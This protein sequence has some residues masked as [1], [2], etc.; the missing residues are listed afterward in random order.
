MWNLNC[1]Q[2]SPLKQR[3]HL[4][5][6]IADL[7]ALDTSQN[8]LFLSTTPTRSIK[9]LT[10]SVF[11]ISA[12]PDPFV[13]YSAYL[14]IC[15]LQP[16]IGFFFLLIVFCY[17]LT[18]FHAVRFW[19]SFPFLP[20]P[21]WILIV[22]SRVLTNLTFVFAISDFMATFCLALLIWLWS[23]VA[24]NHCELLF[25]TMKRELNKYFSQSRCFFH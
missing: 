13:W 23:G 18:K 1:S 12:V 14:S 19:N 16:F 24:F 22:P 11:V 15:L 2:R 25:K 3:P 20:R 21:F 6:G 9:L 4:Y 17:C 10:S 5:Y 7:L 8:K